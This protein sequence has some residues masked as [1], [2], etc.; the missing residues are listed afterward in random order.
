MVAQPPSRSVRGREQ[1][2]RGIPRAAVQGNIPSTSMRP[3]HNLRHSGESRPFTGRNVHPEGRCNGDP[4]AFRPASQRFDELCKGP[5]MGEGEGETTPKRQNPPTPP[6]SHPDRI[7]LHRNPSASRSNKNSS[8]DLDPFILLQAPQS[9]CK[10]SISPD[11]PLPFGT[12]GTR[13]RSDSRGCPNLPFC[14]S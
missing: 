8:C 10:F 5:S 14:L 7:H 12:K 1:S 4:Q 2:E 6:S 9:S 13:E 11:P 3:L